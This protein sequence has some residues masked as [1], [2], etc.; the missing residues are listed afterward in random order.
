MAPQIIPK[1]PQSEVLNYEE[2]GPDV[3]RMA[4]QVVLFGSYWIVAGGGGVLVLGLR[5]ITFSVK[6]ILSVCTWGAKKLD[7]LTAVLQDKYEDV[8]LS[9]PR[10]KVP[11]GLP[12]PDKGHYTHIAPGQTDKTINIVNQAGGQIF[13]N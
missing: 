8:V 11:T 13:I 2:A 5:A 3:G 4:G 12:D 1:A 9:G 10:P 7:R 6:H